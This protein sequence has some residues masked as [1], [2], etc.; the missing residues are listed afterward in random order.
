MHSKKVT[1]VDNHTGRMMGHKASVTNGVTRYST[2]RKI[3]VKLL[4]LGTYR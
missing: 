3:H 4:L 2:R 1:A